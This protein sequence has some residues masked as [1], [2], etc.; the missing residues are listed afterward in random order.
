MPTTPPPSVKGIPASDSRVLVSTVPE[1]SGSQSPSPNPS[2]N[3]FRRRASK[4]FSQVTLHRPTDPTFHPAPREPTVVEEWQG[5][6][7]Y[8]SIRSLLTLRTAKDPTIHGFLCVCV[9]LSRT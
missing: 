1:P 2:A 4:S 8:P 5:G 9:H 3:V 7:L 6:S